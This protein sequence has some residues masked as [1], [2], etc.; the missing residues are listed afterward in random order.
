MYRK[1]EGFGVVKKANKLHYIYIDMKQTK[2]EI[3]Q[4]RC[5]KTTQYY[6]ILLLRSVSR[7]E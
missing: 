3:S 2:I 7:T 4:Y 6:I 1:D 5:R